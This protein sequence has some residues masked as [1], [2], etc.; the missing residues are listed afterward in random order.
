MLGKK[1]KYFEKCEPKEGLVYCEIGYMDP[2]SGKVLAKKSGI[3]IPQP[4][5][6][7]KTRRN[8]EEGMEELL[9]RL[10]TRWE[11]LKK[12]GFSIESTRIE[13]ERE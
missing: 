2:D 9:E 1:F 5:G 11:Q 13:I 7:A 3:L 8:L 4:A 12:E 10:R 6:P